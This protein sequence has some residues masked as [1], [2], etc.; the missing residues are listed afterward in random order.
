M[1]LGGSLA[2]SRLGF[3]VQGFPKPKT[4]NVG[5]HLVTFLPSRV[6]FPYRPP[7]PPPPLF[8]GPFSCPRVGYLH[9]WANQVGVRV[10]GWASGVVGQIRLGVFGCRPST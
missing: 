10:W 3:R 6:K 2:N 1:F 5:S 8:N 4:L 9:G 7:P